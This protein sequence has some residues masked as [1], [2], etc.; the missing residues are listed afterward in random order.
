MVFIFRVTTPETF[1]E[2]W[3]FNVAKFSFGDSVVVQKFHNGAI[4]IKEG[5]SNNR[6]LFS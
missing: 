4:L 2:F 1:V 3:H 5:E 6:S